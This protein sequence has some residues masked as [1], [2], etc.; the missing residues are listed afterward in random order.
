MGTSFLCV[1]LVLNT[2]QEIG[3]FSIPKGIIVY[4]KYYTLSTININNNNQWQTITN[5]I[6]KFDKKI[7]LKG[8]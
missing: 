1:L 6:L 5:K 4:T 2:I 3:S 8:L 7:S